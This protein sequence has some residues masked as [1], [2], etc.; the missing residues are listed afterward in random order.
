MSGEV[1]APAG[2]ARELLHRVAGSAQFQKSKRLRDL[3][4]YVGERS[5]RDP[6]CILR[7][8][9]IGVDV[10]GRAPDYDTSHDTLVRVQVS[11]LRKKLQEYF[12]GE[13]SHEP[14]I[15]EIPKGSYV[16]VFRARSAETKNETVEGEQY[17]S[18]T[19]FRRAIP[20]QIAAPI[21]VIVVLLAVVAW[22]GISRQ[23]QE[24]GLSNGPTVEA[25][26]RQCFGNGQPTNLIMS[27]VSLIEFQNALGQPILLTDY[28]V[29]DFERI[30]QLYVKDRTRREMAMVNVHRVS[31]SVSDVQVARD[32]GLIAFQE[33]MPLA[34]LS[35]RDASTQL[36][37]TENAILLG[38]RRANPWV[39]LFEEQL[40]FRTQYQEAP[41]A[42]RFVNTAPQKGEEPFY[43]AVWR[44]HGYCRVAF[45]PS[46]RKAGSVL[47]IS[48][49]DVISSEAGGRFV[50][51]EE[52]LRELRKSLGV[53]DGEPFPHF[54][55]LLKTRV[56]N[57]NIPWFEV[58]AYRRK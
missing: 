25:F 27:D 16:P 31:T 36:V 30:A 54:E 3:L 57:N 20:W 34:I 55:V 46:P 33:K 6:Q 22:L 1:T 23:R 32:F 44:Q 13:G 49:T 48:G 43:E 9:E 8:Q 58:V 19:T 10:L 15:I 42:A 4:L 2:E 12:A 21:A 38:S 14:L 5:L 47:L 56:V 28:E 50:T 53:R 37:S 17:P 51:T 7:E 40:N 45:L 35:A 41:P 39:G 52:S 24:R 29:K 18:V 11:Q 26:W